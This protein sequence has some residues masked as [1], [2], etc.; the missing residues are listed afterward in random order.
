MNSAPR[1]VTQLLVAWNQGD[2]TA[3]DE[4]M[5]LVYDELRGLAR[6][7][8]RR[9]RANH[10][11]QPS[12]LVHEAYLR[13]VNQSQTN[14]QNRSHFFGIAARIMR[15]ILIT[16]AEAQLHCPRLLPPGAVG[17]DRNGGER[18]PGD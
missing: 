5:P 17:A 10:T 15:Q 12:A 6:G 16:H 2:Q 18:G 3:R 7:Y 4:L 8:L 9:E 13:L 14:W 1:D 11:L